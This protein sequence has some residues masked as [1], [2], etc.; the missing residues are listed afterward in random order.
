MITPRTWYA[1]RA[2]TGPRAHYLITCGGPYSAAQQSYLDNLYVVATARRH[3][4]AWSVAA[5]SA[6]SGAPPAA[7][8]RPNATWKTVTALWAASV[9]VGSPT[10]R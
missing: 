7:I 6:K 5:V 2:S 4:S 10:P 3:F 8:Q 9:A 1:S